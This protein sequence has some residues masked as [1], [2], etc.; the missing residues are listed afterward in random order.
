MGQIIKKTGEYSQADRKTRSSNLELYR[1][2]VM[3]LIVA[4]HYVVNSGLTAAD[5][6]IFTHPF[7]AKSIF[8]LLFGMWGKTGINCF[9]LITG[10]FMC[11]SRITVKKFV[12]LLLEIYFYRIFIYLVFVATGYSYFK[13]LSFV[14][15][16]LPVSSV[17]HNFVSC[18]LLF[19][20]AI[21]FLNLLVHNMTEKQHLNLLLLSGFIYVMVGTIPNFNVQFNYVSWFCVLFFMGSYLRMYPKKWFSNVKLWGVLTLLS[22]L[23]SVCSVLFMHWL[24]VKLDYPGLH[25]WFVSDS[26]KVFAVTTAVASFMFFKN[27]KMKNSRFI[28]IVAES[29][30]GVLLIHANSDTMRQWLWMDTL[31]NVEAYSTDYLYIHGFVSVICIFV[32]CVLIDRIRIRFIEKPIFRCLERFD[33]FN[34]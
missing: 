1:I 18:Y 31:K 3:L 28:N 33:V 9:V 21:P 10:Y 2:I 7:A 5:G 27:L 8:L 23:A 15:L 16:L 4:H 14:K 12:K 24:G 11:N 26:N 29:A 30:F 13:P 25:Y 22:L 19:F 32:V 20:L 34:L 17:A 6:P